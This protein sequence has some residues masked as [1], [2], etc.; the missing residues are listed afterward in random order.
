MSEKMVFMCKDLESGLCT[1]VEQVNITMSKKDKA[2][3][4][5][6][7]YESLGRL[8]VIKHFPKCTSFIFGGCESGAISIWKIP[9]HPPPAPLPPINSSHFL[10]E[11]GHSAAIINICLIPRKNFNPEIISMDEFGR[12]VL[13]SFRQNISRKAIVKDY[14]ADPRNDTRLLLISSSEI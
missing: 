14:G 10:C 11:E 6:A 1:K 3:G 5:F 8:T 13:W 2:M 9:L 7:V 12:V 4:I